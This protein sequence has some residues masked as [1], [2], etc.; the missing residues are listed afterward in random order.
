MVSN[1]SR[2]LP[3]LFPA[4]KRKRKPSHR[5]QLGY[6]RMGL[7]METLETRM[8]LSSMTATDDRSSSSAYTSSPSSGSTQSTSS[9]QAESRN[10][11]SA[12]SVLPINLFRT[13]IIDGQHLLSRGAL[14]AENFATNIDVV[15]KLTPPASGQ[16]SGILHLQLGPINLNVLGLVINTSKICLDITATPGDGGA[17]GDLLTNTSK[18][19]SGPAYLGQILQGLNGKLSS[20]Q[21]QQ[22][23]TG[24][25]AAVTSALNQL[26]DGAATARLPS[27]SPTSDVCPVLNLS[28]GPVNLDLLGLHVSL[29]NCAGGPVTVSITAVEGSGNLLGNLLCDLTHLADGSV[30]DRISSINLLGLK[31]TSVQLTDPSKIAVTGNLL[32]RNFSTVGRMTGTLTPPT[33]DQT[34]GILHLRIDPIHLNLLGLKVDTSPICL[35]ITADSGQGGAIGNLLTNV[36]KTLGGRVYLQDIRNGLNGKLSPSDVSAIEREI[37]NLVSQALNSILAT[38]VGPTAPTTSPANGITPILDLSVGPVN[39]DLLGL[40]VSLDNCSGGPVKISVSAQTGTG[41]ILG[42]LLAS[43]LFNLKQLHL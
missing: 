21:V 5:R 7:A 14:A 2:W 17:L 11:S 27:T 32:N 41:R 29:D 1:I 18:Q 36:S 42:N 37:G 38:V 4:P 30:L 26:F 35:D 33:G 25:G 13:Q 10:L 39:L 43:L 31:T 23:S 6:L 15:G 12:A 19:L 16:D 3:A 20:T 9:F 8:V 22:I 24:I 34:S 28:L 40:H